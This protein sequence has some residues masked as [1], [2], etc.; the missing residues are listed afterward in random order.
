M[1]GIAVTMLAADS[2][3]FA[4][5]HRSEIL[6]LTVK[7]IV[8]VQLG[9]EWIL[10]PDIP[11]TGW[12]NRIPVRNRI[13]FQLVPD[14]DLDTVIRETRKMG[15]EAVLY[16]RFFAPADGIGL[17]GIGTDWWFEAW[18]NS[19]R[20]GSTWKAG[21]EEIMYDPENHP[22]Y[23]PV[24]KGENLLT[25]RVRRGASSWCFTC[26]PLPFRMIPYPAVLQG[27]WLTHPDADGISIRFFTAG[28]IAAGVEYRRTGTKTWK[29]VWDHVHGQIRRAEFHAVHLSGLRGDASYDYRI[30]M[31]DPADLKNQVYSPS[32]K[33]RLPGRR[34]EKFSF[35]FTADL[36]FPVEKQRRILQ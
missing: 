36:Q 12:M 32:R 8:P 17:I 2:Q 33:F 4:E 21:N 30:V 19:Q 29:T 9:S 15:D 7:N 28:K 34:K 11:K 31:L 3:D 22:F 20:T 24:K 5:F 13:R 23:I 26:A 10:V 25:V 18:V 35:F 1:K 14:L 16:N 6:N 27:P